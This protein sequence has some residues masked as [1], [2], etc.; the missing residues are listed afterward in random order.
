MKV[1]NISW[2]SFNNHINKLAEKIK[3]SGKKYDLIIGIARGGLIPAVA[4]SHILNIPMGVHTVKSYYG[5]NK[6]PPQSDVYVSTTFRIN[7]HTKILLV[8]EL[9]D[10]GDSIKESSERLKKLDSDIKS[11]DIAVLYYKENSCVKPD[12]FVKKFKSDVWL[13]FPWENKETYN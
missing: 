3:K 9:V 1:K 2:N 10:S 12:Y 6:K 8:D 13:Y 11:M 5:K 7:M 4:L